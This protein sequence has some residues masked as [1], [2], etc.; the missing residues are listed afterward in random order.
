MKDT[1]PTTPPDD[2]AK[3]A[4]WLRSFEHM[5][6]KCRIESTGRFCRDCG[7]SMTDPTTPETRE[8]DLETKE[9]TPVDQD[10]FGAVEGNCPKCGAGRH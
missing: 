2:A 1:D 5:P 10:R 9:M 7:V 3:T 4:E 8:D 6:H